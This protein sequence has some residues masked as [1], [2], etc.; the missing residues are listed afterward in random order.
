MSDR[1]FVLEEGGIVARKNE[2]PL[3]EVCINA[4]IS[5][6]LSHNDFAY[7]I[8]VNFEN[9]YTQP[10]DKTICFLEVCINK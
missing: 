8:Y 5:Q 10:I 9:I 2:L 6:F 7:K 4:K 3:F 1:P